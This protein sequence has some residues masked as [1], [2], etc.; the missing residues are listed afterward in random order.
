MALRQTVAALPAVLQC[1]SSPRRRPLVVPRTTAGSVVAKPPTPA[2]GA[3][4]WPWP[5]RPLAVWLPL[6][7]RL[8]LAAPSPA[9]Q[10]QHCR[11][12]CRCPA[13]AATCGSSH[14]VPPTVHQPHGRS[15]THCA[16]FTSRR[17]PLW[18]RR[19]MPCAG[20]PVSG[21]SGAFRF[22]TSPRPCAFG[23]GCEA[24]GQK[25]GVGRSTRQRTTALLG[26]VWSLVRL[27]SV[28]FGKLPTQTTPPRSRPKVALPAPG[29]ERL[30]S[31][32][33]IG[34][35]YLREKATR[36]SAHFCLSTDRP[37]P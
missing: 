31:G 13:A 5:R 1:C 17:C 3:Q 19:F 33:G 23:G 14:T 16:P 2:G 11:C 35:E 12:C 10:R 7:S 24:D 25:F 4:A 32:R 34:R 15:T 20:R 26:R 22:R 27:F 29:R 30:Q 28:F 18:H 37:S 36:L 21:S 9:S 8:C 6:G